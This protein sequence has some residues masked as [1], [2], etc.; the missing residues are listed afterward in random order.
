MAEEV[1]HPHGLVLVRKSKKQGVY[2]T[3]Y[4]ICRKSEEGGDL[5]VEQEEESQYHVCNCNAAV[6][7]NGC[8]EGFVEEMSF[9]RVSVY[10]IEGAL[11]MP[12]VDIFAVEDIYCIHTS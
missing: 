8:Q 5:F 11:A 10:G 4:W 3:H 6:G 12:R 1:P 7:N 9:H 2:R